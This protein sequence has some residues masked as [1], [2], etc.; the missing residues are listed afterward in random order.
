LSNRVVCNVHVQINSALPQLLMRLSNVVAVV[1]H[2][3]QLPKTSV[4]HLIRP[5]VLGMEGGM[6]QLGD[7]VVAGGPGIGLEESFT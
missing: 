3:F 4:Q 1:F 6:R 7:G 5:L 2:L